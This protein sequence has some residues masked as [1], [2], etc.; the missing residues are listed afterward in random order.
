MGHNPFGE[1]NKPFLQSSHQM[2]CML[3]VYI[4]IDNSSKFAA[5]K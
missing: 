1:S 5:T 3:D 2:N 4:T